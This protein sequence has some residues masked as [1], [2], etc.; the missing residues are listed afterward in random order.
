MGAVAQRERALQAERTA[1]GRAAAKARGRTGGRPRIDP[2]TLEAARMLYLHAEMT[3]AAVCR[4][5]GS[6]RRTFFSY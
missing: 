3:A 1:A 5:M 6:G 2:G 4:R